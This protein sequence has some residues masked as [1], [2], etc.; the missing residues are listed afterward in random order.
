M[1]LCFAQGS[2]VSLLEGLPQQPANEVKE[3]NNNVDEESIMDKG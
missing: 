1:F 2:S 3:E